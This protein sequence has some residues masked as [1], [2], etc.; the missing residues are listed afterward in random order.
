[1]VRCMA[2]ARRRLCIKAEMSE[3]SA[4]PLAVFFMRSEASIGSSS[5]LVGRLRSAY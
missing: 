5:K 3:I 1:M 2:N 4:Y